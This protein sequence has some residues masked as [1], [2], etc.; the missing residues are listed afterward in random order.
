MAKVPLSKLIKFY[1]RF[2]PSYS[3]IGYNLRSIFWRNRPNQFNGQTWLVTGGSEGIGASAARQ[4]AEAGARVICVA[5]D[6]KKLEAFAQS[7]KSP[8]PITWLTADFSR[9]RDVHRLLEDIKV[10]GHSFDVLVN[11]V[12][13]QKHQMILTD[14]EME[15]SFVTNILS[16][17]ILVKGLL[18]T[19][20]LKDNATVIEVASGGMYNHKMVIDDLNITDPARYAGPRAYGL[21]KRAQCMT[22]GFWKEK[23][24]YPQQRF[25][26]MHPGWVDTASVNRSMPRFVA[27]LKSVLRDH[28]KGADTIV[29]L[30]RER[31]DQKRSEAIWF[32]RKERTTHIYAHTPNP[33]VSAHD[34]VNH[35]DTIAAARMA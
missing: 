34:V 29:Y 8:I 12:G 2:T 11:N 7:V 35:L 6:A 33:G 24:V 19:R 21:A 22:M 4:A 27:I 15:T 9:T 20:I 16:H 14:E 23:A 18:E 30:A 28:D 13:I 25:Y 32:D 17:H 31:P 10:G 5:R 26:A 1:V 3:A